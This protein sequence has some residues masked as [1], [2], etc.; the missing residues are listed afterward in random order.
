MNVKELIL[1]VPLDL[2]AEQSWP[3]YQFEEG[4]VDRE[5]FRQS[6]GRICDNI[7]T[8][9]PVGSGNA[10]AVT[11][12]DPDGFDVYGVEPS[13]K[14]FSLL[15]VKWAEVLGYDVP[16]K[17]IEESGSDRLAAEILYEMTW[18]ASTDEENN[19]E[20]GKFEEEIK[21]SRR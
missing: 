13:G 20:I 7:R 18:F 8:V 11:T 17:L 16:E 1:S 19:K 10:I 9:E 6:I 5:S 21:E 15:F 14:D 3:L 12:Y 4:K 2:L